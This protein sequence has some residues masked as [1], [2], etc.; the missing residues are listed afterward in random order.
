MGD[1]VLLHMTVVQTGELQKLPMP[2]EGYYR[3]S[4][5][6]EAG[7][8][9]IPEGKPSAQPKSV[10]WERLR[11]CPEQL[12]QLQVKTHQVPSVEQAE[13]NDEQWK[14]HLRLQV[15]MLVAT[16]KIPSLERGDV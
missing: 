6:T 12:N 1:R 8:F 2:N 4:E 7:V 11:H 14:G 9:I 3:I 15:K 5:M 13:P 16:V 10:A